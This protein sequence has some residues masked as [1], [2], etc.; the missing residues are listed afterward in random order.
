MNVPVILFVY[1]RLEHTK[2]TI[3]ALSKNEMINETPVFIFCD[4]PKSNNDLDHEKVTNVHNYIRKVEISKVFKYIKCEYSNVN[5]GLANS[6]LY[7]V[8]SIINQYG[9]VIVLEDDI[10]TSKFFLKYMNLSLDFYKNEKNIWSISGYSLPIKIPSNYKHEIYLSYRAASWG[11][12]TWKDRWTNVDWEIKDFNDFFSVRQNRISFNKGGY[13]MSDMLKRQMNNEID[14]WAIRF[15]Y[16]QHKYNM[17]TIYPIYSFVDNIGFDGTGTHSKES[18]K[19]SNSKTFDRDTF[20]LRLVKLYE[21]N[22][23]IAKRFRNFY[24]SRFKY[25]LMKCRRVFKIFLFRVLKK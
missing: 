4:G 10:I 2:K 16:N 5:K 21:I 22:K 9:K 15:C 18:K 24:M 19:Y 17:F 7:G 11:W 23:I 1:N 6:V 13:D 20:Y 3:E 14:S 25:I 12:A 8:N